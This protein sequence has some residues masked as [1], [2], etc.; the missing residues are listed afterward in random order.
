VIT[1]RRAQQRQHERCLEHEVWR[2]FYPQEPEGILGS[3]F[4][5]LHGLDESCLQPGAGVPRQARDRSEMITYV[6]EGSLARR[7]GLGRSY[8]MQAGEFQRMNVG[9]SRYPAE[10]NASAVDPVRVFHIWLHVSNAELEPGREQRR[11][12]AAQRRGMLCLVA[13]PDGRKGSLRVNPDVLLHSA[14]LEPGQHIVH[15]LSKGRRAWLHLVEGEVTLDEW[16]LAAGDGA[17]VSD[18]RAV[19]L[20]ARTVTEI[21]LLDLLEGWPGLRAVPDPR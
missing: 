18:T 12:S 20:T 2:T 7:D 4:G 13:S 16:V 8:L 1:L 9:S 11:F 5:D 17:G 19:S 3:S 21:L 14:L 6:R 15:E 10:V